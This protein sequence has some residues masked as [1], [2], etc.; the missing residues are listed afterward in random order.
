V[1]DWIAPDPALRR[2]LEERALAFQ[3]PGYDKGFYLREGQLSLDHSLVSL[4][5]EELHEAGRRRGVAIRMPFW[6]PDLVDFLYRTPPDLLNHGRRSKGLV[7]SMLDERF[8]ELGFERHKKVVATNVFAG[9]LRAEGERAL[10]TM[11]EP[12][13]LEAAGVV[14]KTRLNSL[15]TGISTGAGMRE[16]SRFW[17]VLSLEA[18]LRPR[19]TN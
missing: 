8:P 19:I 2:E 17:N 4:E 10:R 3:E 6:D 11:E 18:W 16:S 13:A 5:L 1:P 15:I 9:V 12:F 14:D 7:R